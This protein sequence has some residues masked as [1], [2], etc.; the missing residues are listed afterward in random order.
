MYDVYTNVIKGDQGMLGDDGMPGVPVSISLN[1]WHI[2]SG[3]T[4][5]YI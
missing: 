4:Y 2:Y 1:T 3:G 5:I